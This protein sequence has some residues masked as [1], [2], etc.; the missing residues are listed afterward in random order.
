MSVLARAKRRGWKKQEAN[1]HGES[2]VGPGKK[3]ICAR[4]AHVC[5]DV[6]ENLANCS[7]WIRTVFR[8]LKTLP[9]RRR[10]MILPDR[11]MTHQLNSR[12]ASLLPYAGKGPPRCWSRFP[13]IFESIGM[14]RKPVA[15]IFQFAPDAHFPFRLPDINEKKRGKKPYT[16]LARQFAGSTG[17]S[18]ARRQRSN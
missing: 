13:R 5:P 18:G 2:G 6:T 17:R 8:V 14:A 9:L 11:S 10:R 1:R 4:C 15:R 16:R 7:R 3:N 12:K